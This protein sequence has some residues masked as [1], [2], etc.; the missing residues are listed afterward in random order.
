MKKIEIKASEMKVKEIVTLEKLGITLDIEIP[1]VEG[2]NINI[3]LL[4][5]EEVPSVSGSGVLLATV[6]FRTGSNAEA[7]Y[8]RKAIV[9]GQAFKKLLKKNQKI[10]LQEELLKVKSINDIVTDKY[11][12]L[13]IENPSMSTDKEMAVRIM[14]AS[15]YGVAAEKSAYQKKTEF[16]NRNVK[17]TAKKIIKIEKMLSSAA[18]RASNESALGF[19][20]SGFMSKNKAKNILDAYSEYLPDEVLL[21]MMTEAENPTIIDEKNGFEPIE[22]DGAIPLSCN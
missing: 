9:I 17:A 4:E 5:T 3:I 20:M 10:L 16:A 15:K 6:T 8:G 14:T 22:V 18:V 1:K 19:V 13:N 12:D 7:A 21:S 11:I 2:N